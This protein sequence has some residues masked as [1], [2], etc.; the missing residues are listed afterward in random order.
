MLFFV[1]ACQTTITS[2]SDVSCNGHDFLCQRR[3]NEVAV[4]ATHNS[5][6]SEENGWLAPNHLYNISQ[7]LND[8][9]RGLNVDTYLWEGEAYL[10]HGFCELGSQPLIEALKEIKAFIDN[11]PNEV[12]VMTFQSSLDADRTLD[13]FHQ[14]HLYEHL[15]EHPLGTPWPTLQE[16]IDQQRQIVIF[17]NTG[18]GENPKYHEQWVHWVDNPYSAQGIDDFSCALERGNPE[19]ATLYNVNHFLTSPISLPSLAEEGNLNPILADHVFG[20]WEET[21][22]FPNQVLVDFYSIGDLF[23]VVEELNHQFSP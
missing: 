7:Q 21:D 19:T 11:H 8:G 9:I 16:L 15:Y 23:A 10:C 13:S 18:G 20:C 6:S 22:R 4:P 14:S 5:M 3:L 1:I 2:S 17:S 12:L